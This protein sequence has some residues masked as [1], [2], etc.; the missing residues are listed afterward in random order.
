MPT[1]PGVSGLVS[2]IDSKGIIDSLVNAA[3]ASTS[4]LEKQNTKSQTKL[5]LVRTF[6]T[7]LLSTQ[8]DLSAL[9]SS[10]TFATPTVTSSDDDTLTATATSTANAGSFQIT[11]DQIAVAQQLTTGGFSSATSSIGTGTVN[12]RL[13]TGAN[14]SISIDSSN[15]TLTGLADAI[16]QANVGVQAQIINDG[17]ATNPW[18]LSLKSTSTGSSNTISLDATD[19]TG[20]MATSLKRV[21]T[22]AD[23]ATTSSVT[24]SGNSTASNGPKAWK[25]EIDGAGT[26]GSGATYQ[27]YSSTDDGAT[28]TASGSSTASS[29]SAVT[30]GDGSSF[31]FAAGAVTLG[32]TF[33]L[34]PL[35]Q[36]AEAKNASIRY[37]TGSAALTVS[38]A[39]NTINDLVPGVSLSLKASSATAVSMTIAASG[40]NAKPSVQSFI[41]SYND[42]LAFWKTNG[43]FN[44]DTG[45]AGA[46]FGESDLKRQ[47]DD[48]TN[49]L[50]GSVS[51]LS[52]VNTLDQIGITTDADS[53][54][55]VF[56]EENF[57]KAIESDPA[58]VAKIFANSGDSTSSLVRFVALSSKTNTENPFNINITHAATKAKI[59][60][61]GALAASTIITGSNRNLTMTLNGRTDILQLTPG[62]YTQ[63][64]LADHINSL[65]DTGIT[66]ASEKIAVTLEG[67]SLSF[68]SKKYGGDQSFSFDTASD[69]ASILGLTTYSETAGAD[70]AGTINGV[71]ATGNGQVLRGA[72]DSDSEGLILFVTASSTLSNVKMTTRKGVA[73]LADQ[74]LLTMTNSES[75]SLFLKSD[76]LSTT[77]EDIKT[78]ITKKDDQLA[79]RRARLELQFQNM[80]KLMSQFSNIGNM[81]NNSGIFGKSSSSSSK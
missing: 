64:E 58:T 63:Q 80:E 52:G 10:N 5:D 54:K 33:V 14:N 18:R 51:G 65:L 15:N 25:V 35:Q 12:L 47:L 79:T 28:W 11:V 13:G 39:S 81:L 60:G 2:G 45:V 32:D 78:Q 74:A 59:V 1:I 71:A 22:T 72:A 8:L 27:L 34:R 77:I 76:T 48:I 57:D 24:L 21:T 41:T 4:I 36:I 46:L 75:G 50:T 42:V 67:T 19:L 61:S 44:K 40:A 6:N 9:K 7:K 30:L 55:L 66:S 26:V 73:Q 62:T 20:G 53:G 38:S 17:S 49:A 3:R 70:V 29:T 23:A 56:N 31:T 68:T 69:A 37:G 16:N 43:T